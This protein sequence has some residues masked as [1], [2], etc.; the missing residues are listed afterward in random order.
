MVSVVV[1]FFNAEAFLT[2]AVES[3]F[4][5]TYTTWELLLV[6]DGSTDASTE[7]AQRFAERD[8]GRVRCLTHAGRQNRGVC[9]SRNLAVRHARGDYIALLDA[10]DVWLPQKLTQQVA[11]L[12]R[13]PEAAMVYGATQYWRSWSGEG[14]NFHED[15]VPDLGVQTDALMRPPALLKLAAPL[16]AAITPCPSDLLCRRGMIERV[17]GFEESFRGVYQ[18][19]E[20][21]AFLAKVYLREFV[22]VAGECWDRYRLHAD[23]C[24]ARVKKAGQQHSARL[25]FLSWLERYLSDQGV[26]DPEIGAALR[27]ALWPY[28][29]PFLHRLGRRAQRYALSMRDF[30]T[31]D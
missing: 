7:M 14:Q 1:P 23:S 3:V 18:L 2:E 9:A 27:R 6:D 13:H 8:P 29:Q 20:D 16:G 28:R 17:G 31:R 11:I 22:F 4:G 10:D 25:F 15:D 24:V 26:D 30:L 19:Y 21:R 5:Q 12:G